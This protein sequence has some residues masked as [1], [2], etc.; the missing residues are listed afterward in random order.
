MSQSS[1][2]PT[3]S[4]SIYGFVI[5]LIFTCLFLF[6]VLWA[7]IPSEYFELLGITDLPDKYFVL[8]M[9]VVI[10]TA[11][12]IFAFFIYPSLSFIMTPNIDSIYTIRDES[13][14]FR[15][16]YVDDEGVQ[17]NNK[18]LEDKEIDHWRRSFKCT[19]HR[20]TKTILTPTCDC[21]DSATC[22]L[23]DKYLENLRRLQNRQNSASDLNVFE[24]SK[25]LYGD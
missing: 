9:P 23:N 19:N 5:Y 21:S 22:G 12:T 20:T 1:P 11:T 13:S 18:I 2:A 3:P 8:F 24:V 10:L 6:Y 7:F 15:C 16:S 14:I 17:C 4:R 25:T